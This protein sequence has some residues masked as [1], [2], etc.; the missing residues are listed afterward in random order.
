MNRKTGK[1][2]GITAAILAAIFAASLFLLCLLDGNIGGTLL[3]QAITS[4]V[5][6]VFLIYLVIVHSDTV[7]QPFPA[8][9]VTGF[10]LIVSLILCFPNRYTDDFGIMYLIA[11]PIAVFYGFRY[12]LVAITAAYVFICFSTVGNSAI[13]IQHVIYVVIVCA[14]GSG[15]RKKGADII[16]AV[17]AMIL[18]GIVLLLSVNL[19]A[20]AVSIVFTEVIVI[21]LN[22]LTVFV[23]Y[24]L[25]RLNELIPE[26]S[27]VM[28]MET[29]ESIADNS[30]GMT[31][32]PVRKEE[33]PIDYSR[34]PFDLSYLV[35]E[36]CE[37]AK[38][39]SA[40]APRAFCRAKEIAGFARR[41]SVKFGANSDL[42]YAAAL[43]HD[44]AKIYVSAP[45]ADVMLPEC[46]YLMIKR[47][48][49]KQL[50]TSTEELI[51][52]LS[53]HLLAIHH[54][55]EKNAS[56]ISISKVIE[57]I[58]NLQLKKGSI[59]S[60]GI[61]MSLYH[62]MKQEFTNEFIVYLSEK[63]K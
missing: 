35:S 44:I 32:A 50:P 33:V 55:M 13:E 18:Q 17:T 24:R 20:A 5:F 47:Q 52:L 31:T 15:I 46:L 40:V 1:A 57:N 27:D 3:Y 51:V 23:V 58:F 60:A 36:E 59:M 4:G 28:E 34:F 45:T 10:Y 6:C 37:V 12:S 41:V 56:D 61:S 21:I 19:S 39:I 63:T 53:N 42:V 22:S 7:H 54:Y 38:R 49:E 11:I 8:Y 30:A 62:K 9:M 29:D 16:S 26:L 48:N 14:A 2:V 43:Y 25:V